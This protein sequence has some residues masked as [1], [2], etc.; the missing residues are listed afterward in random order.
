MLIFKNLEIFKWVSKVSTL[1]NT[2]STLW[3]QNDYDYDDDD[4]YDNNNDDLSMLLRR[5]Y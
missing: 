2:E 4:G 5:R 1:W 3:M